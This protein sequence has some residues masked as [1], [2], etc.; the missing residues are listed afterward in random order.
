MFFRFY[1]T[2]FWSKLQRKAYKIEIKNQESFK[3]I[4]MHIEKYTCNRP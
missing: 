2:I 3:F 1:T 4:E